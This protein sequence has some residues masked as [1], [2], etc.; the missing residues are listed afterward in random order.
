MCSKK[1]KQDIKAKAFNMITNKNQAKTMTKHVLHII[2][3]VNS[4]IQHVIQITNDIIKHVNTNG[5]VMI[6]AKKVI[7]GILAHAFVRIASI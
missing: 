6:S 1:K 4:I 2:V 5:K 3:K 7:F